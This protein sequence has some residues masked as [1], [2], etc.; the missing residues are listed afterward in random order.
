MKSEEGQPVKLEGRI[1]LETE[2][3]ARKELVSCDLADEAVV[4]SL[5]DGV[6]FGLSPV[7]SHVWGLVRTPR[8]VREIRDS[9]LEEYD[10]DADTCTRDVR[11]LIDQLLQWNLVEFRNG[12]GKAPVSGGDDRRP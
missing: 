12:N 5:S 2:V 7:A 4:L 11:R 10:V 8:T 3:V 9:L 6:Y 1:D